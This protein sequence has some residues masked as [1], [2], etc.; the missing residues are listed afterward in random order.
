[1][2]GVFASASLSMGSSPRAPKSREELADDN[3][4]HAANL[5]VR[6]VRRAL[7]E[8]ESAV[9]EGVHVG[10]SAT[11][12]CVSY[13]ARNGFGGISREHLVFLD[14]VPSQRRSSWN[15]HC[16]RKN[17]YDYTAALRS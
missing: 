4:M 15:S 8:P 2:L 12:V 16:A 1:M 6:A 5:A 9:F 7:R 3:R 13:R 17:L 11:E 14:G 10:E